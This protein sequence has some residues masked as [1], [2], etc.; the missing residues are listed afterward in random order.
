MPGFGPIGAFPI[1][2]V[3]NFGNQ[4]IS[5]ISVLT[6]SSLI[7]PETKTADGILI[8]STSAVWLEIAKVLSGDWSQALRLTPRQWEE[9][10]AGAYE[11]A[12][13]T[14]TLTPPSGDHGR[15]V[16]ATTKG[17]GCVRIIGSVKAYA[18][19]HVVTADDVRALGGVLLGDPAASKGI[20]STTSTFAPKI[21]EDPFIKPLLPT[22][23]ELQDGPALQAWLTE[24][25][26]QSKG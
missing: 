15:D 4:G 10:V 3:P 24:L 9:M 21:S 8:K 11:R 2:G 25:S 5:K 22:R 14:V 17:V 23:I 18:P 6:I 16:I 12:G 13:Y 26:S 7:I 20:L 1:G 19:G